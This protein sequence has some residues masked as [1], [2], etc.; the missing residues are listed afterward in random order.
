MFL[1]PI[2]VDIVIS[3]WHW[4]HLFRTLI[5]IIC[6]LLPL[7]YRTLQVHS[8]PLHGFKRAHNMTRCATMVRVH[9]S[10]CHYLSFVFTRSQARSG[11]TRAE[12]L[13]AT[14]TTHHSARVEAQGVYNGTKFYW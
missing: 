1:G 2:A 7:L 12:G 11:T 10:T 14:A 4:A 13:M 5:L 8:L 6:T 3:P 9:F